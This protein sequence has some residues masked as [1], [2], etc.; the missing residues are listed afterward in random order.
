MKKDK[1][2]Y[3][4]VSLRKPNWVSKKEQQLLGNQNQLPIL[5]DILDFQE[6]LC[7]PHSRP[8]HKIAYFMV[9]LRRPNWVSKEEQQPWCNQNQLPILL[10]KLRSALQ[11]RL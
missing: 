9:S 4:L 2:A 8:R 6:A 1:I 5:L 11:P 10:D 7:N 3:F